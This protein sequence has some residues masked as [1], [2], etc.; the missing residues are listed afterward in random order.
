MVVKKP[1]ERREAQVR[2]ADSGRPFR[3]SFGERLELVLDS[4]KHR[5][6]AAAI[7]GVIGDQLRK[8]VRGDAKP[9]FEV[10]ARLCAGR[11]FSLDW[12]STGKGPAIAD[13]MLAMTTGVHPWLIAQAAP[14][15]SAVPDDVVLVPLFDVR[16]VAG[17]TQL[18]TGGDS[19]VHIPVGRALLTR[20]EIEPEAAFLVITDGSIMEDT[21]RHGEM[22]IADK[23]E[24]E[25]RED[26]FVIARDGGILIRRLQRQ[27]GGA[28]M[29]ISDNAAYQPELLRRAEDIR[30]I[31][32]VKDVIRRL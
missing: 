1:D 31:G 4:Y 2:L 6:E 24:N 8:Y 7:A 27:A 10:M 22:L 17:A 19:A 11:G 12:L 13:S 18:A 14:F 23:S 21:I 28:L 3:Q 30:L 16:Q 26:I 5:Q 9:P 32:R 29:L 20:L 25:A 15:G